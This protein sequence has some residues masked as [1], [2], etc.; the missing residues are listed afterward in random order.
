MTEAIS[1]GDADGLLDAF[2]AKPTGKLYLTK[3][4]KEEESI[5]SSFVKI[6]K[7]MY[8][9]APIY[10]KKRYSSIVANLLTRKQANS[11][12]FNI[13]KW[14]FA[15]AKRHAR[16]YGAGMQAPCPSQVPISDEIMSRIERF[17]KDNSSP[18]ANSSK[19]IRVKGEKEK[20]HCS[21]VLL[22]F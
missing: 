7:L 14:A 4:L 2:F 19:K 6:I 12:G 9:N 1:N 3:K 15:T 11:Y 18:K 8:D 17:L 16:D 20:K 22:A 5:I 10:E 21:C 13:S